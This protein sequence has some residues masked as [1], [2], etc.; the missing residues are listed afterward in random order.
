MEVET[1]HKWVVEGQ[2]LL[3]VVH[4]Q[5]RMAQFGVQVF[6]G[7]IGGPPHPFVRVGHI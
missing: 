2:A 6:Y 4:G 7:Q 3:E 1:A 5:A